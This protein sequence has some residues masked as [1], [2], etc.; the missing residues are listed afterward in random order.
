M[1]R[2]R[3]RVVLSAGVL[4]LL[5]TPLV[6]L[7]QQSWKYAEV[8]TPLRFPQDHASHPEYKLEWWYYTGNLQTMTGERFGYQLTF[9]RIGVDPHPANPSR[10]A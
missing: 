5:A 4:L 7:S 6:F 10:W 9:F 8:N 1:R 2:R 3:A